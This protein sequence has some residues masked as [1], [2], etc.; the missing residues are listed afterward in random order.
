M[1]ELE[2]LTIIDQIRTVKARYFRAL[3]TKNWAMLGSV[4]CPDVVCDYRN[5]AV[6]PSTGVNHVPGPTEAVLHGAEEVVASLQQAL[7]PLVTVH[8]GHSADI[9]VTDERH[10]TGI[11]GMSDILRLSDE[12][13]IRKLFGHG[14][15]HDL[16]ERQ[17]T[18]WMIKTLKLV[19]LSVDVVE[20]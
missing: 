15:Y 16:F 18:G 1:T 9:E 5:G 20:G 10:A 11:W 2:R 19:R 7:S 13:P 8:M 12:R 4:L 14:F 17:S 3:D 6:D